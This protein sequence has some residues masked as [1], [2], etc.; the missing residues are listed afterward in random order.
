MLCSGG[1]GGKAESAAVGE[2]MLRSLVEKNGVGYTCPVFRSG[3]C[4]SIRYRYGSRKRSL[5]AARAG[6]VY[7]EVNGSHR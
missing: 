7:A 5:H 4:P 2:M 6:Y 1:V 3:S